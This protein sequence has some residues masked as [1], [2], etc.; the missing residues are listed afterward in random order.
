MSRKSEIAYMLYLYSH[1][2][3]SVRRILYDKLILKR[4]RSG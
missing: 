2:L 4:S 3:F 1:S